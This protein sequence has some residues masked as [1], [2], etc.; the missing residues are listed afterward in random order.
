MAGPEGQ[1]PPNFRLTDRP[2]WQARQ[3]ADTASVMLWTFG[4]EKERISLGRRPDSC[5]LIVVR[6]R[7]QVREYRFADV[8]RLRIFQTDMEGFLRKTGWTLLSYSPE[9]RRD[10]D[11]RQ[12]PRLEE[13]RRWF[14]ARSVERD[15][16][17]WGGK[18][19]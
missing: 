19:A 11:R 4:K 14:D 5:V 9:R 8:T 13:R 10:R 7:D 1:L 17:V 3:G 12:F 15:K 6:G 16:A 2:L 18:S